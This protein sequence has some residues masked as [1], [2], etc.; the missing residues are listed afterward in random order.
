MSSSVWRRS[1]MTGG[2]P[3]D[4]ALVVTWVCVAPG[5]AGCS[6]AC[7]DDDDGG[8]G[9]CSRSVRL[10][11]AAEASISA[12]SSS[13]LLSSSSVISNWNLLGSC[14][15]ASC[16]VVP[17]P[18]PPP[19]PPLAAVEYEFPS[20]EDAEGDTG[21]IDWYQSR[22]SSSVSRISWQSGCTRSAHVS[23]SGCTM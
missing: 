23:H 9:A 6:G 21:I 17:A 8:G 20:D 4:P 1:W 2:P 18:P 16:P 5:G 15:G 19:P 10:S 12:A 11:A 7:D 13:S 22:L 14:E 3:R